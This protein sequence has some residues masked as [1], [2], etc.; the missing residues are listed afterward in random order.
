[1]FKRLL[2][3]L[4]GKKTLLDEA[5]QDSVMM[6]VSARRMY[7]LVMVAIKDDA[8]DHL[9]RKI[10]TMD[11]DVNRQQREV[12]RKVFEHLSLSRGQDLMI[13][14]ELVNAVIDIER[15]G[16][17]TKN[18]SEL[19]EMMPGELQF[20]EFEE[21]Y[22]KAQT[23]ANEVFDLGVDAFARNDL[24]SAKSC[25]ERFQQLGLL[26]DRSLEELI[27]VNSDEDTVPRTNVA[28]VLLLRY[29]KRVGAHLKNIASLKVNPYHRIGYQIRP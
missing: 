22:Q 26:C 15:I 19:I 8:G 6:L 18:I 16:D 23:L 13:G 21:T 11:K 1:M 9:R 20:G 3:T 10:G 12:R 5:M 7:D 17:Y 29:L 25:M 4:G 2:E 24:E 14:L 27:G 28:L